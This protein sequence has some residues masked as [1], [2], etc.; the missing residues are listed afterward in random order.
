[1]KQTKFAILGAGIAG[2][3][4]ALALRERK[5]EAVIFE[6]NI[7]SGGLLDSININGFIFDKAV[8]LSFATEGKVREVFDRTP[9]ITHSSESFCFDNGLWSK[10]PIQNN[11]FKLD[12]DEKVRLIES[13]VNKPNITEI[14]NYADWLVDQYGIEISEKYPV[15][16]TRKYWCTNP[17]DLSITWIGDRMR[18]SELSEILHGAFSEKTPNHYYTKEMRYPVMGG[19]KSFIQHLIEDSTIQNGAKLIKI[20]TKKKVL[21]FDNIEPIQY[22]NLISSLPL[23]Y[24]ISCIE[25]VP[26]DVLAVSKRLKATSMDLISIGF[27]KKLTNHLWF[28]IYDEDIYASRAYSPSVKS[29]NNCPPDCS[30]IQFEIYSLGLNGTHT[31]E[32]LFENTIY[33][34]KKLEIASEEDILF[35]KHHHEPYANVVFYKG[36]E[37]D[38]HKLHAYLESKDIKI[39]GRFGEWAYLWSNQSL[40]SGYN[41]ALN[42]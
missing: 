26:A 30:S 42:L 20:D 36:M 10:H 11:L 1:L 28:Y 33:A 19:Y 23:P 3:G 5:E 37:D 34:L 16:Y 39:C 21:Y 38:R 25:S 32:E 35:I 7:S 2:L 17:K 14:D 24:L 27:N 31:A 15:R 41:A 6:K 4:A 18:R 22:I 8:H 9:Y 13:Y 12:T 40:M 29:P